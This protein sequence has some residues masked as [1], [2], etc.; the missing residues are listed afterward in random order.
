MGFQI[1]TSSFGNIVFKLILWFLFSPLVSIFAILFSFRIFLNLL[2]KFVRANLIPINNPIDNLFCVAPS[3]IKQHVYLG[4]ILMLKQRLDVGDVRNHFQNVFLS[5]KQK[6]KRCINFYCYFVQWCFFIWKKTLNV[7]DLED[8]IKERTVNFQSYNEME[9][10]L[11]EY[12]DLPDCG[13]HPA[14]EILL[15]HSS[16]KLTSER[17]D[18]HEHFNKNSSTLLDVPPTVLVLKLHHSLFDGYSVAHILDQLCGQEASYQVK[19]CTFG[20]SEKVI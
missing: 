16:L 7:L 5:T 14:W 6:Q 12:I 10:Y 8:R 1:H 17:D 18:A 11:G 13:E 15:I 2:T 19:D 3:K 4:I 9:E 20:L